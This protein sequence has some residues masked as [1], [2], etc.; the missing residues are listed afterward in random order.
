MAQRSKN[1]IPAYVSLGFGLVDGDACMFLS[2]WSAK[3]INGSPTEETPREPPLLGRD[4]IRKAL[5]HRTDLQGKLVVVRDDEAL[6]AIEELTSG[7]D[8]PVLTA[9]VLEESALRA[10]TPAP[11]LF[12]TGAERRSA[13]R[14][15]SSI[16]EARTVAGRVFYALGG[17]TERERVQVIAAVSPSN[18]R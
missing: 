3:I 16:D 1:L 7:S 8:Q 12:A 4:Q 9:V 14:C 18:S 13:P 10:R 5:E 6:M 2:N 17:L 11:D 15:D